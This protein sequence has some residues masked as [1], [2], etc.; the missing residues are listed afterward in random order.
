VSPTLEADIDIA[1]LDTDNHWGQVGRRRDKHR[2][3]CQWEEHYCSETATYRIVW[4][5]PCCNEPR[6]E[7]E[8]LCAR[9]YVLW[10]LKFVRTWHHDC[11]VP[12]NEHFRRFGR[13]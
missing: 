12:I 4:V 5:D 9:H 2:V 10:L 8:L 7:T 1:A 6:Q 13:I 3:G 11:G